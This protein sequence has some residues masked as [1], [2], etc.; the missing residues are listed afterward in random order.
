M[1]HTFNFYRL[2]PVKLQI[3]TKKQ[4]AALEAQIRATLANANSMFAAGKAKA[5]LLAAEAT[6]VGNGTAAPKKAQ[7]HTLRYLLLCLYARKDVVGPAFSV[8]LFL[9]PLC[10]CLFGRWINIVIVR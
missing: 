1:I 6:A 2:P 10:C 3:T 4:A 8:P 5:A 7:D 9:P